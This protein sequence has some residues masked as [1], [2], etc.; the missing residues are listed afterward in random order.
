MA[1]K[2]AER[3]KKEGLQQLPDGRWRFRLY[4]DGTKAGRRKMFTLPKNL[5]PAEAKARY[6]AEQAKA[7][8]RAGKPIPR[9]WT[10][11]DA[12]VDY[13]AE[14][15]TRGAAANTIKNADVMLRCHLLPRFGAL[16]LDAIRP[17][18]VEAWASERAGKGAAPSTINLSVTLLKTIVRRA[19]V[20]QWIERDPLPFG[21]VRARPTPGGK[22]TFLTPEEWER[23]QTALDGPLKWEAYARAVANA[24]SGPDPETYRKSLH[25]SMEVFRFL[26]YTATRAGEACSLRW[27]DVDFDAGVLSIPM[28]KVRRAKSVPI[29]ANLAAVLATRPRGTPASLVFT[30]PNGKPWHPQ[31]LRHHFQALGRLAGIR[32]CLTPHSLRHTFASWSMATGGNLVALRDALGHSNVAQTAKYAHLDLTALRKTF[33]VIGTVERSTRRQSG[34]TKK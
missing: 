27:E 26:L 14:L 12:S 32:A 2:R 18:D 15:R 19:I 21:S 13:L 33:A 16:R 31:I 30:Q 20:W 17:T 24:P 11:A 34:A 4:I 6:R 10:L 3:A 8:A 5:T 1:R 23:F 9:G 22:I 29:L 28:P 25:A 7:A